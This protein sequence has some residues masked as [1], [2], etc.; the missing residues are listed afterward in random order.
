[1]YYDFVEI[2]AC[3][4]GCIGGGGQPKSLDKNVLT[5]RM[6][7][8]Y[9]I[10]E[11]STI[12]KSHENPSIKKLYEEFLEHPLSHVSHELLHTTYVDRSKKSKIHEKAMA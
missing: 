1:V 4:A 3:P 10:D 8:I 11:R 6:E 12:R 2:M 5:R 7:G 9:T